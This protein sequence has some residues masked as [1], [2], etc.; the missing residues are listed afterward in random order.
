MARAMKNRMENATKMVNE[1]LQAEHGKD[2]N[3][4]KT[5]TIRPYPTLRRESVSVWV[6]EGEVLGHIGPETC[7]N[8]LQHLILILLIQLGRF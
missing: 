6:M 4:R 7:N 5:P 1:W 8:R 3:T 2:E